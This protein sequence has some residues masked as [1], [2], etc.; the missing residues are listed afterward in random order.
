VTEKI[1]GTPPP[2]NHTTLRCRPVTW[3][4]LKIAVINDIGRMMSA[5]YHLPLLAKADRLILQRGLCDSW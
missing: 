5:D 1:L 2:L 4:W 3:Q